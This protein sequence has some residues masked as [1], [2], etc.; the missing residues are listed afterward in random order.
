MSLLVQIPFI[1]FEMFFS[2]SYLKY[3]DFYQEMIVG[4][5]FVIGDAKKKLYVTCA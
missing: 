3:Q 5:G 2:V 1:I 4:R